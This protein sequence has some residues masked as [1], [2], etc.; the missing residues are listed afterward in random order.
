[1][2][3]YIL[4][5]LSV[6]L[7]SCADSHQIM[8]TSTSTAKLEKTASAYISVPRDGPYGHIN[9]TGSGATTAQIMLLAFSRYLNRVETGN[10]YQSYDDALNYAKENNFAYLVFPSIL[11]WEDRATEWSGL[12]DKV[13]VKIL[14]VRVSNG[15]TLD[16]AIIKGKS[17][18]ATFGGDHPQDLL[19]K[20]VD[21]YVK[22]LF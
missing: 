12:P 13:A 5:F 14:V 16:A 9:Y 11:A 4:L 15:T 6:L 22:S 17:G 3:R 8:K 20:P 19:T 18:L 21:K 10:T 7:V 2:K 1:M